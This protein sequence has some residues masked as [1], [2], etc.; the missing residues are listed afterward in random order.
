MLHNK[1][2]DRSSIIGVEG[3][4]MGRN[5]SSIFSYDYEVLYRMKTIWKDLGAPHYGL[6]T[7]LDIALRVSKEQSHP[8]GN[9]WRNL[10][11]VLL[12]A[13]QVTSDLPPDK[14]SRQQQ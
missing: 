8:V 10:N 1:K 7:E 12:R 3:L 4:L 11:A 5:F 2:V 9:K 13:Y 6:Y 14:Q